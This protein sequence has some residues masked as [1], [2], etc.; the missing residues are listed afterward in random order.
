MTTPRRSTG[1]STWPIG[2]GLEVLTP[3]YRGNVPPKT[4]FGR[5]A[6][7]V[8]WLREILGPS[9]LLA[10]ARQAEPA[11]AIRLRHHTPDSTAGFASGTQP[12]TALTASTNLHNGWTLRTFAPVPSASISSNGD[13]KAILIGGAILSLL[14]GGIVFLLGAGSL[15]PRIPKPSGPQKREELY[16][17]LTGLPNRGLTLDRAERMLARAGRQSGLMVGALFVDIDWFKDVNDKLGQEAGDQL[18]KT[19]GER[20]NTVIRTHDTVGTLRRRR[21]RRA[22]RIEGPGH[23]PGLACPADHRVAPQAHR[24]GGIRSELL[25]DGQHRGRLRPLRDTRRPAPRRA[26]GAVR[27]QGRRQGPLHALQRQ[28]ALGHRG[29]RRARERP[30]PRALEEEQFSLLYQPIFDLNSQGVVA[31]ESLLRWQHPAKGEISPDDFIPLAEESG[32]I[33]P[34]GR[35]VLEQAC[36]DAAAWNVDGH[37]V[38][39]A[40]KVSANQLNRD[41]FATDVRRALQ[42]SGLDA[43]L[44]ILEI[45]ETTVMLDATGAARRLND[46]RQLGV[47]IAIDD[48]GSG[49]AYRSDLQR[50]PI[51]FLKVD[52]SSLAASEDEDYRSWLLEAILVF[53]RDLSLTVIAKGVESQEQVWELKEM[54]CSMAQGYFMGQPAPA[55]AVEELLGISIPAAPSTEPA[56]PAAILEHPSPSAPA[57]YDAQVKLVEPRPRCAPGRASAQPAPLHPTRR[58]RSAGQRHAGPAAG[59]AGAAPRAALAR[60]ALSAAGR[61]RSGGRSDART[62]RSRGGRGSRPPGAADF[63]AQAPPGRRSS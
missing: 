1:P 59:P 51:D 33:V 37:R 8:G 17:Q 22:R 53:G 9:P 27:R 44:L 54:G 10:G 18:L 40:V 11:L 16:D 38:A 19:V 28:H 39:V 24:T 12:H 57:T 35:W 56:A 31:V 14:F 34:I 4:G 41:G 32:L 23:A 46:L 60:F 5:R 20:L 63:L 45:A 61:P 3:V 29:S 49:Y 50:M 30:Q 25:C 48:F 15:G 6:A 52:R 36:A 21:V 13:A 43:S 42:Q 26:H 58:S 47:R 62:H 2:S 7:F 55:G